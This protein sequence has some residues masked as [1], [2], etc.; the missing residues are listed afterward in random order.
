VDSDAGFARPSAAVVA[1]VMSRRCIT[2][3]HRIGPSIPPGEPSP[4]AGDLPP[5]ARFDFLSTSV[6]RASFWQE[7]VSA[8]GSHRPR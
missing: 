1:G 2:A 6:S 7:V 4:G 8:A 5:T 3:R